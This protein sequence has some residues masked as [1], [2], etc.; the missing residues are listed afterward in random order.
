MKK[1]LLLTSLFSLI[2]VIGIPVA[3]PAYAQAQENSNSTTQKS[4]LDKAMDGLN[5]IGVKTGFGQ[6]ETDI[7]QM[8]K[9]FYEKLAQVVNIAIGFVGI[10]AVIYIIYSGFKWMMA[11]GNDQ[12]ITE[13]KTGIKNAVIGLV[14]IFTSYIIVNFVVSNII[15]I[16]QN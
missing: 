13:A 8:E 1:T 10:L 2:L 9:T 3:I 12:V 6:S 11:G 16:V 4:A 7:G 15:S 5:T 14:I